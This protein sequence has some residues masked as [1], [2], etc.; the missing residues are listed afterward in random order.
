[1]S[2]T[3]NLD[4]LLSLSDLNSLNTLL[5]IPIPIHYFCLLHLLENLFQSIIPD[6]LFPKT[7]EY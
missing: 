4:N 3:N 1:M 6:L 2:P 5:Q 7:F